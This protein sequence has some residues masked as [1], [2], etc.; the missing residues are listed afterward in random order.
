MGLISRY[1]KRLTALISGRRAA[2]LAVLADAEGLQ[3]GSARVAWS[4]ISS[5]TVYKRDIYVGDFHCMVIGSSSGRV[6]EINE[7]SPG[8]KEVGDK[9][10]IFLPGSLPHAHWTLRL[11]A[12]RPG[13]F[14]VIYQVNRVG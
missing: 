3:I 1:F 4:D 6:F 13:E 2:T 9:V 14:V 7:S 11:I 10:E 5:V 8:W 12:A